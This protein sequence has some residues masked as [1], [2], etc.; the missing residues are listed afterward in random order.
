MGSCMVYLFLKEQI[1]LFQCSFPI[2]YLL[3]QLQFVAA[4][5]DEDTENKGDHIMAAS[6]AKPEAMAF[7]SQARNWSCLC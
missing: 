2:T 6:L 4:V 5:D 3:L 1:V 7:Y